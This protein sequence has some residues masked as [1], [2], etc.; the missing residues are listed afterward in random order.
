MIWQMI[1]SLDHEP[2]AVVHATSAPAGT[3]WQTFDMFAAL[4]L[5]KSE[6]DSTF[7]V[8][9][10]PVNETGLS[11]PGSSF[12]FGNAE[13]YDQDA[14]I[15]GW[16]CGFATATAHN[17]AKFYYDL[18]GPNSK[19]V[20]DARKKEMEVYSTVDVGWGRGGVYYGGGLMV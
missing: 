14:S 6:Y 9:S 10:G 7:F 4:G 15:M 8:A 1:K 13:I 12:A 20:S 11:V 16:T 19:I 3:T 18:L 2:A 17:V 5:D